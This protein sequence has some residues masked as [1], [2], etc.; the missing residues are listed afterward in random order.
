MIEMET[1]HNEGEPAIKP[2]AR[3][4]VESQSTP[5]K[6]QKP[7]QVPTRSRHTPKDRENL[8]ELIKRGD[9]LS[10]FHYAAGAHSRLSTQEYDDN[11]AL[12]HSKAHSGKFDN[13]PRAAYEISQHMMTIHRPSDPRDQERRVKWDK[14]YK[15]DMAWYA[16]SLQED[17]W[18]G[19]KI[20]ES[21]VGSLQAI[22][23]EQ[24]NLA[25]HF[26]W[27]DYQDSKG[28][29]KPDVPEYVQHLASTAVR[30]EIDKA[31]D[32]RM[33]K[34]L[35]SALFMAKHTG[36][37]FGE[38]MVFNRSEEAQY[39]FNRTFWKVNKFLEKHN[40]PVRLPLLVVRP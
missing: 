11:L 19:R 9:L 29:L 5:H 33:H 30:L 12:I 2:V 23:N 39:G 22:E 31:P 8:W 28:K 13:G 25:Q 4:A 24:R 38:D 40:I 18:G 36:L 15:E 27:K 1:G 21:G 16:Q 6:E 26:N 37:P 35:S 34:G 7:I 10:A 14:K 20:D 32:K 17:F 3:K